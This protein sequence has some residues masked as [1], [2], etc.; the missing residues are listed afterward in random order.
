MLEAAGCRA[1]FPYENGIN[2]RM[3]YFLEG[4]LFKVEIG[5]VCSK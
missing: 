3:I 2:F 1:L 5:S 4:D